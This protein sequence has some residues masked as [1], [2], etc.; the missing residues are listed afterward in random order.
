MQKQDLLHNPFRSPLIVYYFNQ[1]IV[2]ASYLNIVAFWIVFVFLSGRFLHVYAIRQRRID[3][4]FK[5]NLKPSS[6]LLFLKLFP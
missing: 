2:F 3:G 5:E 6:I 1:K 4:H